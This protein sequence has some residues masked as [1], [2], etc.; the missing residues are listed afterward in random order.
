[1]V[2]LRLHIYDNYMKKGN[3][4]ED[5]YRNKRQGRRDARNK[6]R[7]ISKKNKRIKEKCD[8]SKLNELRIHSATKAKLCL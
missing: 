2:I 6:I 1:M 4:R 8:F 5:S 3:S 7:A